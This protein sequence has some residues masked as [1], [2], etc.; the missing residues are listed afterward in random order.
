M[1]ALVLSLVLAFTQAPLPRKPFFGASLAPVDKGVKI[2]QVTPD[3]TAESAGLKPDDVVTALG[4]ETT[5][6][7]PA[8]AKA[9]SNQTT[10]GKVKVV[11]TRG[12]VSQTSE[13]TVKPRPADNG[14]TYETLYDQVV[15]KGSRIRIFVTKPKTPGKHPA[16]FLI[17]GIGYVSNEQPLTGTQG[18]GRICR[19]FSDKGYVTVRVEKPGL[20]DSEGGPPDKVDFDTE[21]DAFRQALLKTKSYDFV[22]PAKVFIFGHSMGG[23]E[24]PILASEIPVAG[25]AV[26]GTVVRTW[27]EYV[28]GMFRNQIS[29]SGGSASSLDA[30]E[31]NTIA[32]LHLL[33]NEG[34]SPDE[35]KAKYPQWANAVNGL[36]PDGQH[37]SGV[38]LPFWRG[39][40]AQNFASYWEKLDTNVLSI[41]GACDFVADRVDHPMIADIVNKIHPGKAKFVE[42][43][44]SD[45][46]FRNVA[47]QKESQEFWSRGGKDMNPAICDVLTNW[48]DSLR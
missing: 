24:G 16:L 28:V 37:F 47:S 13:A 7:V 40:F 35:A 19:A 22:D 41:Y 32:A 46:A 38:G 5:E 26:Y 27:Q 10:G 44:N 23:C 1:H 48:A 31:R 21:L 18:Y 4:T 45:H 9:I 29:L 43:P 36:F 3:T 11:F 30:V 39:C 8:L 12:G 33:F 34:L 20:G 6:S 25:L 14:P 15:S 17:Q 2:V 42:I